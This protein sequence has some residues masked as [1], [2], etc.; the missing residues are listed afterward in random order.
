[1]N[2]NIS[3]IDLQP[4]VTVGFKAQ[5]LLTRPAV[6]YQLI[7]INSCV[8]FAWGGHYGLR[9]YII[10]KMPHVY[11]ILIA[12]HHQTPLVKFL[13]TSYFLVTP[14]LLSS[15]LFISNLV[16]QSFIPYHGLIEKAL[17]L[18]LIFL[19]YRFFLS[20]GTLVFSTK[21]IEYYR[22]RLFSPIM[23]YFF[24]ANI[25]QLISDY[26][27]FIRTPLM[28][29]FGT[30][31]SV[32]KILLLTVGIYLWIVA[33]SLIEEIT[34]YLFKKKTH[35]D[36]EFIT[37]ISLLIRYGLMGLGIIG[38]ISYVGVNPVILTTITGGLSVGIGFG[39][40]EVVSNFVSGIWLFIEGSL[41]P[42]DVVNVFGEPSKVVSLGFR[43]VKVNVIQDNS[44]RIIPNQFF[45]T[46]QVNTYTGTNPMLY[47]GISVGASYKSQP[48]QVLDILLKVAYHHPDV[49]QDPSPRAFF[50][51]FGDSSLDFELK[52]WLTDPLNRKQVKSELGCAIWQA[53]ADAEIEIPFPQTDLHLKT[54][55]S[56]ETTNKK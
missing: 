26:R 34:I 33:T 53:F 44:E 22:N 8:L 40:R 43:A 35:K 37:A 27:T 11:Q 47:S 14:I 38:I 28:T 12:Q 23:I 31:L 21:K 1:M 54:G 29:A 50:L 49:L 52:Y 36:S 13:R 45:F 19:G 30:S 24:L 42:G 2:T 32:Q 18:S 5:H 16:Y 48:K 7:V 17:L 39:L 4:L 55:W 41:K 15:I 6:S 25:L 56:S 51:G 46:E 9:R 3:Q 20:L 10:L